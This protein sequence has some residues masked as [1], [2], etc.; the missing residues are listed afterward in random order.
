M[1]GLTLNML[2]VFPVTTREHT[3]QELA[4]SK[5][6]IE[7]LRERITYQDEAEMVKAVIDEEGA[8]QASSAMSDAL[9]KS[10]VY[11]SWQC[12]MPYLK[13]VKNIHSYRVNK[14]HRHSINDVNTEIL[15]NGG[16]LEKG[17]ILFRGG[18]FL[19]ESFK[20]TNGPIST[21]TMP[22]VA[23]WHGIE[24]HGEIA[25]LRISESNSVKGFAFK[26]KGH[27]KHTREF[28]VLLQ[29]NL[30]LEFQNTFTHNGMKVLSYDVCSA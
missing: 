29:N 10:S 6:G 8:G 11:Q 16:Y 15:Y 13:D 7:P 4:F 14:K 30:K 21:S 22:S 17:Q 18:N 3:P 5:A 20:V 1:N 27:Q 28:E 19:E 23:R 9:Q 24:V 25:I 26:T 2:N 12:A